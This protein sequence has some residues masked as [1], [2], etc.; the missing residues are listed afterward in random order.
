MFEKKTVYKGLQKLVESDSETK[1]EEYLTALGKFCFE[2]DFK[3]KSN[4]EFYKSIDRYFQNYLANECSRIN[5]K[6]KLTWLEFGKEIYAVL[7]DVSKYY[8]L[9]LNPTS[10][11]LNNARIKELNNLNSLIKKYSS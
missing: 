11:V 3:N 8:Y 1:K 4:N 2:F 10:K 6:D 9:N 7:E 5:S